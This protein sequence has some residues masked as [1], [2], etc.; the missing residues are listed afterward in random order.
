MA[1]LFVNGQRV[2]NAKALD[3]MRNHGIEFL[4]MPCWKTMI[5]VPEEIISYAVALAE[6]LGKMDETFKWKWVR[7]YKPDIRRQKCVLFVIYSPNKDQAYK[8]GSYFMQKL[9]LTKFERINRGYYWVKEYPSNL[10]YKDDGEISIHPENN[11]L[12]E[13]LKALIN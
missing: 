13:K 2:E 7:S 12:L 5:K 4:F 3:F 9:E 11:V 6:E 10:H 1:L 8:R